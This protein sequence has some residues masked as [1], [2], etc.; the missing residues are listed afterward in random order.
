[1]TDIANGM[2]KIFLILLLIGFIFQNNPAC[3]AFKYAGNEGHACFLGYASSGYESF[4][5]IPS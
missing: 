5:K 2:L 4:N 3:V 1:M